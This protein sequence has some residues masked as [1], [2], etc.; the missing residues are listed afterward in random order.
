MRRQPLLTVGVSG[1]SDAGRGLEAA[2]KVLEGHDAVERVEVRDGHL[3]VA[4]GEGTQDYSDLPTLL[5]Q[6]GFRLTLFR[7]EEINLE[8]AFM[9]LTKGITA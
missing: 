3:A 1:G 7:E 8:T 6:A 2:A 5:I 4:P 9:A